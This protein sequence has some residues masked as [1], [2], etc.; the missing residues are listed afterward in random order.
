ME[1]SGTKVSRS[2]YSKSLSNQCSEFSVLAVEDNTTVYITLTE[3]SSN[4][5]YANQ[6]FS[7]TLNAGQC[8]QVKSIPDGDFSGSQV[9]VSG[10]KKVA[11]FAGNECANIPSDCAYCDH[12]VE[13]MMPVA[14]WGNHFVVT[15][16]SWRTFDIV[17]VTAANNGCQIFINNSLVTTINQRETY[18]FEI[19]SDDPSMYLETS[20]PA[21]V[22]LYYA[23]SECAGEMGDPSMVI[24]SPI[25][26]RMDYVTFSTF[27]S[28]ASQYHF[29]NIVTNTDDVSSILLDGNSIAS[30]FQTVSGNSGYSYARVSIEHGSHTLF[31]SGNGFV[32]HVYGLGDDESYAYSVGSNAIQDLYTNVLVNGQTVSGDMDVCGKTVTFDLNYNYDVSQVNWTFGDGQ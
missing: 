7:V 6:P 31:T 10:N 30:E 9:S 27:N 17:R 11:V 12:I 26:Q 15:G 19:T 1:G 22:Y 21:M 20:E 23:G 29:V 13:Q 14:C 8:Y 24:I 3:N 18:Q 25:E 32:A 16:S 2:R 5:H 4:G 28:G